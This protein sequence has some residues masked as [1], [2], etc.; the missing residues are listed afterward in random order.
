MA[1]NSSRQI[2]VYGHKYLVISRDGIYSDLTKRRKMTP[3]NYSDNENCTIY[4]DNEN[5]TVHSVWYKES[6][7]KLASSKMPKLKADKLTS[8][9]AQKLTNVQCWVCWCSGKVKRGRRARLV[10]PGCTGVQV[11]TSVQV[12]KCTSVQA[13]PVG[14]ASGTR[15]TGEYR[16]VQ[17]WTCVQV[18]TSAQVCTIGK[19]EWKL[20]WHW[21][22]V[23]DTCYWQVN[24]RLP[25]TLRSGSHCTVWGVIMLICPTGWNHKHR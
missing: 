14:Q 23:R 1:G 3:E 11:C 16:W 18:C 7:N 24:A 2:N 9:G 21:L 20:F 6:L 25:G 13:R 12:F 17:V 22:G 19:V 8:W 10:V 4:N 15:G 5:K